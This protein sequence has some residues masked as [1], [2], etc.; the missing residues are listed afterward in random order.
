MKR[1]NYVA[2]VLM[3]VL[4]TAC[5]SVNESL[6]KMIPADATG[7]VSINIPS[8]LKKAEMTND[9]RIA[10]PA[11]LSEV[12]DG[13]D[14]APLCQALTDLPVMGINAEGKAFAF[15]TDKTFDMVLLVPLSDENAARKTIAMRVGADFAEVEGLS[16]IANRDNFFAVNDGVLFAARVNRA[17]ET[18][19]L[20]RVARTMYERKG[21]SALDV[22]EMKTSLTSDDDVNAYLQ[23]KCI[24]SL[25]KRSKTYKTIAQRMP[26]VEIFTESDIEAMECSLLLNDKDAE[27]TTHFKVAENSDYLKL[28]STITSTP[29]AGFLKVIPN[30]MDYVVAISVNGQQLVKLPQI[31]Q[32]LTMFGKVPYIG[33]IDLKSILAS[34]DGPLAVAM[35]PDPYLQGDW[36]AVIAAKS[37]QSEAVLNTISTFAQAMGQAPEIYDGE[38]VYQYENKMIKVGISNDVLY[39][40]MLNYEQQESHVGDEAAM[41]ALFGGAPVAVAMKAKAGGSDA[42]FTFSL[43]DHINGKGRFIPAAD[44]KSATIALLKALCAIRPAAAYDDMLDSNDSDADTDGLIPPGVTLHQL[45]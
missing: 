21:R 6:E 42:Q 11:E 29:D 15:F 20:A 26:L 18:S 12:I 35:A 32:L 14:A 44:E 40:K 7:V 8:I 19:K 43:S 31:E 22:E 33:R 34:I 28:M 5:G 25:L 2:S 39:L 41:V 23:L 36:N 16:C 10:V 4:M 24:K 30:S 38:Y 37:T 3:L 13:N 17:A 27:L 1:L 9:G 45:P